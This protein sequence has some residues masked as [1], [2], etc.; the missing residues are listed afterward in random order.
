MCIGITLMPPPGLRPC[1][2]INPIVSHIPVALSNPSM[3]HLQHKAETEE[4]EL[5]TSPTTAE[6]VTDTV[7]LGIGEAPKQTALSLMSV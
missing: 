2:L 3:S 6:I 7:H 1:I 4:R 5:R